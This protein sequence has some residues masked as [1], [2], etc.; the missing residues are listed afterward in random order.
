MAS[1]IQS[2]HSDGDDIAQQPQ[3]LKALLQVSEVAT[4]D[5]AIQQCLLCSKSM[6]LKRPNAPCRR[7]H[8]DAGAFHPDAWGF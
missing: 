5:S 8:G 2:T 7:S 3:Y 4:E 6:S 1:H